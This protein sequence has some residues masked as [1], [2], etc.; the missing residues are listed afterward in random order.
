MG[1]SSRT[2]PLKWGTRTELP[3]AVELF[4]LSDKQFYFQFCA[5]AWRFFELFMRRG[6]R[7]DPQCDHGTIYGPCSRTV[8]IPA[9]Y[10]DSSTKNVLPAQVRRMYGCRPFTTSSPQS[11]CFCS[12]LLR[13]SCS[14]GSY[15]YNMQHIDPHMIAMLKISPVGD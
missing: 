6:W 3:E 8:R 9:L 1:S 15:V 13:F 10:C 5:Y 2:V 11:L 7:G 14:T 12:L 4:Q